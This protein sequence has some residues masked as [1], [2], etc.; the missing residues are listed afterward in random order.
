[1]VLVAVAVGDED[2]GVG[3]GGVDAAAAVMRLAVAVV[4]AAMSEREVVPTQGGKVSWRV[5]SVVCGAVHRGTVM[6]GTGPDHHYHHYPHSP[7]DSICPQGMA[8]VVDHGVGCRTAPL[9][10][11]DRRRHSV[12]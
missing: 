7:P 4:V 11:P 12:V 1:M 5:A 8:W 9:E 2:G 6:R 10:C 3:D